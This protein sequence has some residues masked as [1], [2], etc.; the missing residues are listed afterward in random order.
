MTTLATRFPIAQ[1]MDELTVGELG[2]L[3]PSQFDLAAK[4]GVF[5]DEDDIR[6]V[7]GL[8]RQGGPDGPLYHLGLDQYHRMVEVGAMSTEDRVE[9]LGGRLVAKMPAN[10]PHRRSTRKVRVTIDRVLPPGWYSDEQKSVT[11]PLA[12]SEPEPDLQVTRGD[13]DDYPNHHP[14]PADLGLVV[15]VEVADSS[16]AR[17]QRL[18]SRIYARENIPTYWIVNLV[19]R[20]LEVYTDPSGPA[21]KPG[22]RNRQDFGS[23]DEVPLVLDG[24]E[25]GRIVVRDLL[26]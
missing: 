14:G 21:E 16:L 13:P 19:A 1:E 23:E 9:L 26:P 24:R 11:L 5:P 12:G 10:S 15:E 2:R 8:L 18:K 22:Y 3:G 25:V 17:D 20:R 6:L 7:D 4:A